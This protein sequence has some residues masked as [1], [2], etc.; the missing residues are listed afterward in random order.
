MAEEILSP[1]VQQDPPLKQLWN[2]LRQRNK[3]FTRSYEDF[4]VDMQNDDARYQLHTKL[5]ELDPAFN[6]TF[7]DFSSDI[8]FKKKDST[9]PEGG[10]QT[11]SEP[12]PI[13]STE[14]PEPVQQPDPVIS[15][16]FDPG[17]AKLAALNPAILAG[18]EKF[19]ENVGKPFDPE[20]MRADFDK[21][22][23]EEQGAKD[24][25]TQVQTGESGAP[26]GLEVIADDPAQAATQGVSSFNKAVVSGA[27]AVPKTVAV[28]AKQLDDFFGTGPGVIMKDGKL[29][30]K[31]TEDYATYKAGQ[32][33]E[34]KAREWGITA[35]DPDMDD[36][37]WLSAVP[38][39]FGSIASMILMGGPKGFGGRATGLAP[40]GISQGAA[41]LKGAQ[42]IAR[43]VGSRASAAGSMAMAVPEFEAA[44]AAGKSDEEAFKVFLKNYA[45]GATEVLPLERALSRI[46]KLSSGKLGDIILAGIPGGLEEGVQEAVQ[47]TLTNKIAQGSY[48]PKR[49]TFQDV[50]KSAGAGF[51]VGFIL[52]GIGRAMQSM[53][54]EQREATKAEINAAL[55]TTPTE[56]TPSGEQQPTVEE[57]TPAAA[58]T[59]QP[60]TPTS[61]AG[62][63]GPDTGAASPDVGTGDAEVQDSGTTQ[64]PDEPSTTKKYEVKPI[65]LEKKG[66]SF[67]YNP[68]KNLSVEESEVETKFA[69]ELD[70]NYATIKEQY[71]QKHGNVLDADNIRELS[72]DYVSDP[73]KYSNAVHSPASSFMFKMYQDR[74]AEKP[75]EGQQNKVVFIGGG[76]GAGKST[77]KFDNTN[78]A[79]IVYNTSMAPEQ[80]S[81]N[82]V[83]RA[84][85]AG[86]DVDINYVYRDPVVS[87]EN[88]VIPRAI[89]TGRVLPI[90]E[91]VRSHIGSR[92][93]VQKLSTEY[94]DEPRVNIR[95]FD[96]TSEKGKQIESSFEQLPA[97]ISQDELTNKLSEIANELH[98]SGKISDSVFEQLKP[99]SNALPQQSATS[100]LQREQSEARSTGGERGS[101]EPGIQGTDVAQEGATEKAPE[102]QGDIQNDQ[103]VTDQKEDS[104]SWYWKNRDED[105]K[106]AETI[107]TE[108]QKHNNNFQAL[109]DAENEKADLGII[110]IYNSI[111]DPSVKEAIAKGDYNEVQYLTAPIE[112][113]RRRRK[114]K[115]STDQDV[116]LQKASEKGIDKAIN[117]LDDIDKK[118]TDFG[119]ETLGVNVPI[120][121]AQ[122]AVRTAKATLQAGKTVAEAIES[123]IQSVRDSDWFKS[124][125]K[126]DQADAEKKVRGIFT[127]ETSVEKQPEEKP[128]QKLSGIKKALVPEEKITATDIEKRTPEEMLALGR[129][130]VD[131]GTINPKAIV[132][133]ISEG[134]ARA[135]QPA[136][137]AA[138]VYYKAQLDNKIDAAQKTITRAQ[139]QDNYENE[140]AGRA[141]LS[142]LNKDLD[143]YH[144]MSLKTAYEQSLAFRLRKMLLDDEYNLQTQINKYKVASGG[145][146]PLEV[147]AKFRQYDRELKEANDRLKELEKEIA[148]RDEKEAIENIKQASERQKKKGKPAIYGK[149]RI[150][151]GMEDLASALGAVKFAHG[152]ERISAVRA[153]TDIGLGLIEEGIVTAE[154]VI[155]KLSEHIKAKFKGKVNIDEYRDEVESN[156]K[157]ALLDESTTGAIKIKHSL[158]RDL[159]ESGVDNIQDLTA[160]VKE[161]I[162]EEYP[163]ATDREVRDAITQYG[164]TVNLSQDE[165]DVEIRKM[166]RIGRLISAIEDVRKGKRPSRSGLQRDKPDVQERAMR[167]DLNEMMKDLPMNEADI[168]KQW[169]TAL[170][171]IKSRLKN[172]I[173][174]LQRRIDTGVKPTNKRAQVA[175]DQE[176]KDLAAERDRLKEVVK[177]LEGE[178]EMTAEQ[179]AKMSLRLIENAAEEVERR[180]R[181]NDLE[182]AQKKAPVDS[183]EI[184][185]ARQRLED[186]RGTL[187]KMR[188]DAGIVEKRRLEY[189]KTRVRRRIAEMEDRMARQDFAPRKKNAPVSLDQEA[190]D[191][192]AK[193]ILTK[194]KFDHEHEKLK[195][196]QRSKIQKFWDGFVEMVGLTKTLVT[197]MDMS[198]PFRQGIVFSF[199]RPLMTVKAFGEM[200]RQAFSQQNADMW[201]AHI[202]SSPEY[203]LM[204]ASGLYLSEPNA[205]LTAR[206]ESYMVSN[207]A[208]KI[209]GYG[210]IIKASERS[211]VA[212]L[213]KQRVDAFLSVAEKFSDLGIDPKTNPEEYKAWADYVNNATGRGSLGE[214]EQAAKGLSTIF[215]SPRL[216][217]SRFN[218]LLNV[219]KY[220][221]MPP[222][223][224][225]EAL[226]STLTFIGVGLTALGLAAMAGADVEDDPRSADFGKIKIGNTRIDPWGG[227]VQWVVLLSRLYTNERKSTT[228]GKI[229]ELGK[230]MGADDRVDLLLNFFKQKLAPAPA[231]AVKYAESK[232][233]DGKRTTRF[234]EEID[235]VEDLKSAFIP[236]YLRDLDKLYE[237]HDPVLASTLG[238]MSFFGFGIQQYGQPKKTESKPSPRPY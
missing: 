153:L 26:S 179:K 196:S 199:S 61:T 45:V 12:L 140:L 14:T 47:S 187:K 211:Y 190:K 158:I 200:F 226:K 11:P 94:A 184:R 116:N 84:L 90:S 81:R 129:Q 75:S 29:S 155:E 175:L 233:K 219:K 144:V 10:L 105:R 78:D 110:S 154:N 44:K 41:A 142:Q 107:F 22:R 205:K 214:F 159:V 174:D 100:L 65:N 195:L 166:K 103:K 235:P 74:L 56:E 165:I 203:P 232:V 53:T 73:S 135:L 119:K 218:I 204:K 60:A 98:Q 122:A 89:E 40:Q 69:K 209:P 177:Q 225:K 139:V 7:D 145:V 229:E 83:N 223:A 156:I 169:E 133:E 172:A 19:N 146:I 131:D 91:I 93:T 222:R 23:A 181:E 186:L 208:K 16:N 15:E 37:F 70:D 43:S 39:G 167:K 136:E 101:L 227:F 64:T 192:E 71:E 6:R 42:D 202:K 28:L 193:K 163:D 58:P 228:T 1:E 20:G 148:E 201:L 206:E 113:V 46:N 85:N 3:N 173:E 189:F 36:S 191:L 2:S 52:P 141:E 150:A 178:P 126:E 162:K 236:L 5:R 197:I 152:T 106:K 96:N 171:A 238:L 82:Q 231:M 24:F 57:T 77:T 161:L 62:E 151:K 183:P 111:S 125:P 134:N 35:T 220:A 128:E 25:I 112:E 66:K 114:Q 221:E 63:P 137:V 182:Y 79:Q 215:F 127:G 130:L 117:W 87:F 115:T 99:K 212:F 224:R 185:A 68:S 118:L 92:E 198:A 88:G 8:G 76:A 54:P 164:K 97:A 121:V 34:D 230:R 27:A 157:S 213:N 59:Q 143:D 95:V 55:K 147:E 67:D 234:G 124:L 108:L 132:T 194:E 72:Q 102:P 188:E 49:D 38:Q 216:I 4:Q 30:T 50:L 180:I 207:W 104:N 176:A 51:F 160:R 109:I 210:A 237:E 138:L 123:A 13:A 168:H 33:L 31:K 48:D 17:A 21:Q 120:V 149:T 217:T 86:K 18:I 80:A 9:R 32:W 170:G